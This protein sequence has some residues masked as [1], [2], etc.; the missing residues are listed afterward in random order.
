MQQIVQDRGKGRLRLADVPDPVATPGQVV[1]ANL[2]SVISAGTEKMARD[3]ARKSLLEK[4]RQRPDQV[5]RVLEKLAQ[6]GL[7]ATVQQVRGKLSEPMPLGYSSA[8]VA[9]ACGEGVQGIRPGDRV[10]S[11][12]AHA[13][14]VSV[15]RNLCA[16]VP[17]GVGDEQAAFAVL[18]AIALQGVRLAGTGLGDTAFVV[19]LGLVGQLAVALLRAAGCRVIGTDLDAARCE[20]ARRMGAEVARPALG[21]AEVAELTGGLG[22]DAVLVAAA[23]TSDGPIALAGDAVRK[24]GRVVVLGAVGMQ[25]P[26]TPYYLKEAELVVSC[27]YGPGRYDPAYEERGRDYPAAYVRW[28]EQRN[29]QAV[30]ELMA[31]GRLDVE[32]LV[33]HRFDLAEAEQAYELIDRGDEP[34]L[35]VVLRYPG[36]EARR[37][38]RAIAPAAVAPADGRVGVALV[39]TGGFAR[40]VLLPAIAAAG[41]VLRPEVL[42]SAR[43]LSAADAAERSGF[44]A[45]VSD[46]EEVYANPRVQAVF[47]ATRHD[48][49]AAQVERALAAGKHVFVEKPLA[50]DVEGIARVEQALEAASAAGP[51]GG[52]PLLMVGFNRRFSPAAEEVRRFFAGVSAP[53]TVSFRFNAGALE[54]EHWAQDPEVGG[55]RIVGEACHAIDLVTYLVGSPPVRVFAESIGGP[56]APAITD[57]QCFITLRHAD[58]SVSSIGYL[59][60]GDRAFPKERVEVFGGGRVAVIDDFRE[61]V[62][63]AGGRTRRQRSL[64]QDKGHRGEVERFARA[65]AAGGP[66]PIPWPELRAV[67]LAAVLAVRSLRE[68]M[69]VTVPSQ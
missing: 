65:V 67:S 54:P 24:K 39:G 25:V 59:A 38:S 68:G 57:D 61:V 49:H 55:G 43:G 41:D 48:L 32:P 1:I 29:L 51:G 69:P 2:A 19:G 64:Q 28:T 34:F 66:E 63:V 20:L 52:R 14:L 62:T 3:L 31:A 44:P 22:A 45:A 58:G 16:V 30:L 42:C 40:A 10:A 21:G 50:L 23:T 4:A 26:R 53:R 33:S 8:G 11:N 27:S 15:P 17:E 7:A 60:G 6:E 37:P 5:R 47:I 9:L 56:A 36:V 13:E 18:G 46:E 35:G 12:G